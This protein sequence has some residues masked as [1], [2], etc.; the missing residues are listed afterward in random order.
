MI[1]GSLQGSGAVVALGGTGGSSSD[2]QVSYGGLGR[3][4][5]EYE[6]LGPGTLNIQPDPSVV[7]AAPVPQLWLI[8]DDGLAATPQARIF[9]IGG[10]GAPTDP[11]AQFG[12]PGADVVIPQPAGGQVTVIVETLNV[13]TVP[14][15]SVRVV[16]NYANGGALVDVPATYDPMLDAGP[17]R[18]W[19]ATISVG[20]GYV[21]IQARVSRP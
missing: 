14:E 15:T 13:E 6:T 21:S 4:R 18:Y 17:F 20:H 7:A 2:P 11:S 19:V 16:A 9:S 12:A 10:E 1:A 3:I 5:L 8:G